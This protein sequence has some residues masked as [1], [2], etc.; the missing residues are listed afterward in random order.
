MK[1]MEPPKKIYIHSNKKNYCNG[2][3]DITWCSTPTPCNNIEYIQTSE[4]KS[5]IKHKIKLEKEIAND[6]RI[7][8]IRL[9][10]SEYVLCAVH[11]KKAE[12][13]QKV[14]QYIKRA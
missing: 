6:Y 5:W 2:I 4:I 1:P 3:E 8:G 12:I 7:A 11:L 14:L 13:L 9:N 10:R